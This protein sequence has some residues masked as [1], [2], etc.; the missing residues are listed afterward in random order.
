MPL[1]SGELGARGDVSDFWHSLC[2][3][4]PQV[5]I[6]KLD[7]VCDS[8]YAKTSFCK[9]I[10]RLQVKE[11]DGCGLQDGKCAAILD[12]T[13]ITS[14]DQCRAQQLCTYE[15]PSCMNRRKWGYHL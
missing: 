13:K 3:L 9:T 2:F 11:Q 6:D 14:E 4:G 15:D 12:C 1:Q 7:T 10:D 5:G 8:G